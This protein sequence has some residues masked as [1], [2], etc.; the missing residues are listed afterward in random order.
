M[1]TT[2]YVVYMQ[3]CVV[4]GIAK[5]CKYLTCISLSAIPV[6]VFLPWGGLEVFGPSHRGRLCQQSIRLHLV[7]VPLP[8]Q[9]GYLSAVVHHQCRRRSQVCIIT[10][11][12]HT[13]CMVIDLFFVFV[14]IMAF[15]PYRTIEENLQLASLPK[16]KQQYNVSRKPVFPTIPLDHVVIDNL[17]LFL[18]VS[19]V[20]I[21]QLIMELLRLDAIDKARRVAGLD[22]TKHKHVA[23]FE[24]FV[25]SLGISGFSLFLGDDSKV[26]WRTFTGE[27]YSQRSTA[28]FVGLASLGLIDMFDPQGLRS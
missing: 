5:P 10:S 11:K 22:R 9:M 6:A 8:G 14:L 2:M 7:Q 15:L 19:D 23:A 18:R 12:L 27:Q 25:G 16:S 4:I 26:K 20:L 17:H 1:F 21:D 13:S 24:E 28:A 3:L